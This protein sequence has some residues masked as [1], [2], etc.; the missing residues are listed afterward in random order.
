MADELL[1]F[2][3]Q[4]IPGLDDDPGFASG[5]ELG[6]LLQRLATERRFRAIITT[7]TA[8]LAVAVAELAGLSFTADPAGADGWA[9]ITVGDDPSEDTCA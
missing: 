5:V 9:Q 8:A 2:A 3:R 6:I 7:G 4:L 1:D